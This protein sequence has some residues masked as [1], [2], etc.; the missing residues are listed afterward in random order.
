M[1]MANYQRE[2]LD[3]IWRYVIQ[4][5][6][7]K[8][9][10]PSREIARFYGTCNRKRIENL[11]WSGEYVF[12]PPRKCYVPKDDGTQREIFVLSYEDRMVM[13]FVTQLYYDKYSK[14]MSNQCFA[15]RHGVSVGATVRE[16]QQHVKGRQVAK[17]DL[18]KYFDSVPK[19]I[20]L[21]LIDAMSFDDGMTQVLKRFYS[22]DKILVDDEPVQHFK[23][24]CQGCAFSSLLANLIL[25]PLDNEMEK[26]TLYYARY[27][28]DILLIADDTH[29]AFGKLKCMLGEYGLK[30]NEKKFKKYNG[31][32]DFL[33]CHITPDAITL[34]KTRKAKIKKHIVDIAKKFGKVE[35]RRAQCRVI[36]SINQYLMLD[37]DGYSTLQN[38]F[39]II[40]DSGDVKWLNDLCRHYIRFVYTGKHN[41]TRCL[42]GTPEEDLHKFGWCDLQYLY[43]LYKL[44]RSAFI[45]ACRYLCNVEVHLNSGEYPELTVEEFRKLEVPAKYINIG[46]ADGTVKIRNQCYKISKG[47]D[48]G[49]SNIYLT[50]SVWRDIVYFES[51]AVGMDFLEE[52]EDDVW[53][54]LE[55]VIFAEKPVCKFV[56]VGNVS[57][58]SILFK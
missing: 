40:S 35:D 47:Y 43:D 9:S 17:I 22:D 46:Y 30:I 7:E 39:S 48:G 4:K 19:D 15:Y 51:E 21:S 18:S 37:Q 25:T 2:Y 33:G 54:L 6:H 53:L 28:D 52:H 26:N 29:D 45:T 50:E 11:L 27:S 56:R 36:R 20:I 34:A 44:D 38:I 24:L 14:N 8:N 41:S 16:V 42:R 58:P 57:I 31:E 12:Q 5:A 32:V 55:Y 49:L 13:S 3:S 1:P 10:I 23:S